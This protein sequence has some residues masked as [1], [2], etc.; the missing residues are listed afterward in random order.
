[1]ECPLDHEDS[2]IPHLRL[3]EIDVVTKLICPKSGEVI[4]PQKYDLLSQNYCKLMQKCTY[5][6][7]YYGIFNVAAHNAIILDNIEDVL[8]EFSSQLLKTLPMDD[9]IFIANL[10]S[11]RLLPGNLKAVIK[12]LPTSADKA[13]HFLDHVILPNISKNHD[14]FLALMNVM[15]NSDYPSLN[16][17][18]EEIKGATK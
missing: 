2:H 7:A 5:M 12:S 13:D 6:H 1:L 16:K 18:A 3:D 17:L 9:A 14:N 8:I 10:R 11:A 15:E 4:P